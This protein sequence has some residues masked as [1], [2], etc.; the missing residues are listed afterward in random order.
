MKRYKV[1]IVVNITGDNEEEI[2]QNL[3]NLSFADEIIVITKNP[4][5]LKTESITLFLIYASHELEKAQQEAIRLAQNDWIMLVDSNHFITD[6]LKEEI[7]Q[8]ISRQN[9]IN[10][11]YAKEILF[12]FGKSIQFGAFFNKRKMFLLDRSRYCFEEKKTMSNFLSNK[13]ATL[14]SKINLNSY[15]NFDDYNCKLNEIRKE[16]A[17]LLFKQNIKPNFYHFLFK[18]F[19]SFINQYFLKLGLVDGREG[20]ILA[21]INSFSILKRYLVLWL[22]YKDM[23]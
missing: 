8:K 7:I 19:F 4:G 17:L 5:N 22:L 14:K 3:N 9:Y 10:S 16:E 11:F 13:S 6:D 23:D 15:S 20:F 18:P 1:S 21:Y 12:F 2:N